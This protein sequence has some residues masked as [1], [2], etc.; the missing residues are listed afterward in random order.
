MIYDH[1]SVNPK[2][3]RKA[4]LHPTLKGQRDRGRCVEQ[5]TP[6]LLEIQQLRLNQQS[7][8]FLYSG[9]E[10]VRLYLVNLIPTR[11]H[12]AKTQRR[13]RGHYRFA[14]DI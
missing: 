6:M 10:F 14:L 1:V 2:T 9:G 13:L 8:H 4:I 12:T 5:C 11:N 3:P 7:H